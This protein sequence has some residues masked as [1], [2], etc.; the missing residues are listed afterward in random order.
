[1]VVPDLPVLDVSVMT[2]IRSLGALDEPDVYA[3]VARLFL[4]DVPVHLSALAAA[5]AAA[6]SDSVWRIAHRLR[7]S[8]LEMGV[9]RMAPLCSEIEHAARA[10][11]LTDA[12]DQAECLNRE[13]AAAR[14][15]MHRVIAS[16]V[17][18]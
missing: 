12:A 3:E 16:P 10:G 1:M 11:L 7:G 8:V 6:D 4:I 17:L 5:I 2:A 9:V 14:A 18:A 13:F 15:A